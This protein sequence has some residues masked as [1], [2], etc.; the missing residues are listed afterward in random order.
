MAASTFEGPSGGASGKVGHD[1]ANITIEIDPTG[2]RNVFA[3][4]S[5]TRTAE[6][7]IVA[8]DVLS[9]VVTYQRSQRSTAAEAFGDVVDVP[10]GNAKIQVSDSVVG[11]PIGEAERHQGT[12]NKKR[13]NTSHY[14]EISESDHYRISFNLQNE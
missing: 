7:V 1:S 13:G 12:T 3:G 4:D 5:V 6:D 11:S 10:T 8:E 9:T 14:Q 2:L